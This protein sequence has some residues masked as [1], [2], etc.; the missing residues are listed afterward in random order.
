[1]DDP[2]FR[3]TERDLSSGTVLVHIAYTSA[4]VGESAKGDKGEKGS[5]GAV[6]HVAKT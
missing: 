6:A 5:H 4:G 3:D 2:T 1:L